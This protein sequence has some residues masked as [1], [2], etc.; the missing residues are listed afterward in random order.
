MRIS[1]SAFLD[2]QFLSGRGLAP[3]DWQS[4]LRAH[5]LIPGRFRFKSS[6]CNLLCQTPL[7]SSIRWRSFWFLARR[8]LYRLD[9]TLG[10]MRH[11]LW[12]HPV[13]GR[14]GEVTTTSITAPVLSTGHNIRWALDACI[15]VL[16]Q[17][18]AWER[19][20][21]LSS[22]QGGKDISLVLLC[23]NQKSTNQI[24]SRVQSYL[25]V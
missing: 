16:A 22:F 13:Q 23:G 7:F 21:T 19:A 3:V 10:R 24:L 2:W 20:R 12:G 5:I 4:A 18:C 14:G 25:F 11:A 9:P 8:L 17:F 1:G 6:F 15:W